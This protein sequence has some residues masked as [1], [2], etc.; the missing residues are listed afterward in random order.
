MT[1]SFDGGRDE[2]GKQTSENRTSAD[3]DGL[4]FTNAGLQVGGASDTD[5]EQRKLT[6]C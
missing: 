5:P 6:S 4:S 3:S 1:I 2:A